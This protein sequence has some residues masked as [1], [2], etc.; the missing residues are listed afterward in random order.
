MGVGGITPSVAKGFHHGSEA[1]TI[2]SD[3]KN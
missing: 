3:K 1:M 2:S